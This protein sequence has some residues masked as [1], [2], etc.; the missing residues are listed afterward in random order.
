MKSSIAIKTNQRNWLMGKRKLSNRLLSLAIEK[1]WKTIE[2]LLSIYDGPSQLDNREQIN[3]FNSARKCDRHIR[4]MQLHAV[5]SRLP[6]A[7]L[8][9]ASS[10]L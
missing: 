9:I 4:Y 2:H 3:A 10:L 1:R 6:G 5:R 7:M 8:A